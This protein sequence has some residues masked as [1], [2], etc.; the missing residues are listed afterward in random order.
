M[1]RTLDGIVLL[2]KPLGLSSNA[3]LQRVKWLF[4]A[5]KAGH[6]GS[7]DPLAS[8]MLPICFGRATKLSAK[9]LDARKCYRFTVQLGTRTATA[10]REGEVIEQCAVPELEAAR[11]EGVLAAFRGPQTQIPPMYSALKHQG[12]R[13]YE[14][15]R[16]GLEV[17][18][19]PRAIR[20]DELELESWDT[21]ELGL[22]AVCSKGTY[23]R[24]LAEDIARALG[25]CGHVVVLRRLWVEPFAE[26]QMVSLQALEAE[27]DWPARDRW[28]VQDAIPSA[29]KQ[30]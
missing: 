23:I 21:P 1:N 26:A 25:S 30:L 3:A 5:R 7:L 28:C 16:E 2:D 12:R 9:L 10:D 15:A 24:V 29:I 17:E 22:R 27:P 6:S 11:I 18:R 8:G 20:I 4:G 19:E 13:L 14:L